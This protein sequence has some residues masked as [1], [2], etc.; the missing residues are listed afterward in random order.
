MQSNKKAT[1]DVTTATKTRD[2][3]LG[4]LRSRLGVDSA[5]TRTDNS[6]KPGTARS[7]YP[8]SAST[9]KRARPAQ[10][11]KPDRDGNDLSGIG[12]SGGGICPFC[13]QERP[14]KSNRV[15][16][17]NVEDYRQAGESNVRIRP[18]TTIQREVEDQLA[19][20]KIALDGPDFDLADRLRW[21]L[22]SQYGVSITDTME[23]QYWK[24]DNGDMYP[25][26]WTWF[27]HNRVLRDI[28]G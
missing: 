14:I 23:G 21:M 22:K 15:A 11:T 10:E 28:R 3:A 26:Q 2:N 1:S 13:G 6:S 19:L 17:Q 5:R 7:G 20:R 16:G 8:N 27:Q 24:F 9:R 25:H 4:V 12:P 18:I